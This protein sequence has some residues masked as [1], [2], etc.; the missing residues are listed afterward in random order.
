[1]S[2]AHPSDP[3]CGAT[4]DALTEERDLAV[5][6]LQQLLTPDTVL[7]LVDFPAPLLPIDRDDLALVDV[8]VDAR[9]SAHGAVLHGEVADGQVIGSP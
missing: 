7:R 4:F 6:R 1:M 8:E 2:Q 5:H 3:V 9:Q